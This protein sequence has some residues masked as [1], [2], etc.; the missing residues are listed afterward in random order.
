MTWE[1]M[2]A[3][4]AG[5]FALSG[6]L[7]F[8]C[9]HYV[10]RI[11]EELPKKEILETVEALKVQESELRSRIDE[12]KAQQ[13]EAQ[14][15]LD[16]ATRQRQWMD[17]AREERDQL[18]AVRDEF[19]RLDQDLAQRREQLAEVQNDLE[20]VTE[21]KATLEGELKHLDDVL[22]EGRELK[23]EL[24]TLRSEAEILQR[25][26]E[27]LA[28][29][30]KALQGRVE[31]QSEE[32]RS[33]RESYNELSAQSGELQAQ[34]RALEKSIETYEQ[35]AE[36]R[37]RAWEQTAGPDGAD[38]LSSLWEPELE[39]NLSEK[40]AR[41]DDEVALLQS[42][43]ADLR[44]RGLLFSDRVIRAFHTS[45]KVADESP[46][47]VLAGIS[48]TGKSLL[49][50]V[51]ADTLG[52][53]FHNVAVQPGWDSPLDLTGF[54]SHVEGK[55][56]PTPLTRALLQ[57]DETFDPVHWK[58]AEE[59]SP[60][61]DSML[62]V[63]LDEMNL[64]RIEYYFS[65]FLSRLEIRRDTDSKKAAERKRASLAIDLGRS[66]A[67][68]GARSVLPIFADQNVLFV[69]TM[70][71][72][73]STQT[74]SDKVVDRANVL[75]FGR[76]SKL[77]SSRQQG[78]SEETPRRL[79]FASWRQWIQSSRLDSDAMDQVQE[80]TRIANEALQSVG[81]PFGHRTALA[82][83]AYV[84]RYPAVDD[85]DT[86]V[87]EA[88]ADQIEQKVLPKL[89][90]VDPQE[91]GDVIDRIQR[92]VSQELDDAGLAD[93]IARGSRGHAFL[94]QGYD[95]TQDHD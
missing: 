41:T 5:G 24:P 16:E 31:E 33:L 48:G 47:L 20:S 15:I 75:R 90:G 13:F 7:A 66:D 80:W 62:L 45:L 69:G 43:Q 17:E 70:N 79:S 12:L 6:G 59:F 91:S 1:T 78:S 28:Q 22:A 11:R 32:L 73:E 63:L 37:R 38:R 3:L 60:I 51:Y 95:R 71:E 77:S 34:K 86:A 27:Q 18:Q 10:S 46:L 83:A 68:A 52:M 67:E 29:T 4:Y 8:M 57:M 65:D 92:L 64:A 14:S 94:W 39:T 82:I 74:L 30:N 25:Q 61:H 40:P 76:P 21:R 72:D 19:T 53:Y 55:F 50:R 84:S 23:G 49:P 26:N 36:D 81:R 44:A 35:L 56:K 2:V 88:M 93:E 85:V 58:A 89:R 87:R 42:V 9:W 54:F